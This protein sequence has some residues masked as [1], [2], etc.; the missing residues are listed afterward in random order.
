MYQVVL[1]LFAERFEMNYLY[2]YYQCQGSFSSQFDQV[3]LEFFK[4]FSCVFPF[5]DLLIISFF[6]N[7]TRN[8]NVL[9]KMIQNRGY[10]VS[11][12]NTFG[13]IIGENIIN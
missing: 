2:L 13:D 1:L 12:W 5:E 10:Y 3:Q 7:F 8:E 4:M 11:S 9:R 6:R